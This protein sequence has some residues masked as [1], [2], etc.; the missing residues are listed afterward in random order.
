MLKF[1]KN[2]STLKRAI[3]FSAAFFIIAV[4]LIYQKI[5][6]LSEPPREKKD[7]APVLPSSLGDST[8]IT[9]LQLVTN[10]LP[11]LQK[12]GTINDASCLDETSV[13]GIIQVE[14]EQD[15]KKAL[16]YAKD[17]G[18]K[19]SI[20][21]VKHSMGGHAFF[22]NALVL[23][24][25]KFNKIVLDKQNKTVNVQSGATWHQ[26]QD[27]LHP[28]YAIKAMQSTDIFTVGGSIS[29]NAHGM[30]HQIGSVGKTIR[31]MRLM[32]ADG[33]IK[34]LSRQENPELF[35]LVVGGYGL[36]G[37]ILDATLDITENEI[38]DYRSEMISYQ[39]FPKL[40]TEKYSNAEYGLFY[41]HLSTAP[42]SFLKEMIVYPYKKSQGFDGEVRP[43]AEVSSVKLRRFVIN[44]SKLGGLAREIKWFAET[45]IEPLMESC[46][47]NRNQAM[48][49]GEGCLVS[50]NEP[51]HDSVPYLRNNLKND[52]DILHEYFIP[53]GKFVEYIDRMRDILTKHNANLLNASVRVVHKEDIAL[54]YA[55]DEAFSIVLYINQTA[56]K[57]GNEKMEALT[58]NL[59]D[60]TNSVGGRFFLPYQLYYSKDQ[61]RSSYP[62]IDDFFTQ[63]KKYDSEELL[64]NTFYETYSR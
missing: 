55:P 25:T 22:K 6:Y 17:N 11:W 44:L 57:E 36:F 64:T 10:N 13:S 32:L 30:D 54:N 53:R 40:F 31:S 28:D 20:A 12:G 35:N 14:S 51:M 7:C 37:V 4:F 50:R 2:L 8:K 59:I 58:K 19:V 33:S 39:D 24:M 3:I 18:L 23:D 52:T 29:V 63:K 49:D 46:L 62:E 26:I 38:Y 47:V 21:G 48:K 27:K 43:L 56:D 15:I 61:L 41:A 5:L 34:T 9:N 60:L 16:I 45:K 42:S 1:L